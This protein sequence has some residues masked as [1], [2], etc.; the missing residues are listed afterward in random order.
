MRTA[1]SRVSFAYTRCATVGRAGVE[2]DRP[3][4]PPGALVVGCEL[5]AD[6]VELDGVEALEG[7]RH[8][9]VQ[10][11]PAGRARSLVGGL[12]QLVVAEVVGVDAARHGR[13]A[14]PTARRAPRPAPP[15]C[16]SSRASS[17]SKVNARPT[18]AARLASSCAAR[19]ELGEPRLEHGLGARRQLAGA[20]SDEPGPHPLDRRTAGCPRSRGRR[21]HGARRRARGPRR[22]G[23]VLSVSSRSSGPSSSSTAWPRARGRAQQRMRRVLGA[24]LLGARRRDDEQRRP[25]LRAQQVV[26]PAERLAVA[27]LHVVDREQQRPALGERRARDSA[28]SSRARCPVRRSAAAGPGSS[29]RSS[30][31]SGRSRAS[32]TS[33]GSPSRRSPAPIDSERSSSTIG[34]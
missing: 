21:A 22:R 7:L 17:T 6:A 34:A 15:R 24:E 16:A 3:L 14:A 18:V 4:G 25:R 28:S 2:R 20:P 27:P 23:P 26:Q 10:H 5:A 30:S 31:S 13:S 8:A 11:A 9:A 32:S 29:G 33:H 1:R 12:A 19:G